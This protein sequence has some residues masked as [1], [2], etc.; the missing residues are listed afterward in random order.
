[1]SNDEQFKLMAVA[2]KGDA[3]VSSTEGGWTRTTRIFNLPLDRETVVAAPR[4][5]F[6]EDRFFGSNLRDAVKDWRG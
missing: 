2:S 6:E 4:S 1:M 3:T 5:D